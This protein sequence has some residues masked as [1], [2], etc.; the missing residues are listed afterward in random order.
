[1]PVGVGDLYESVVQYRD[2][3][4]GRVGSGVP[5]PQPPGHALAGVGQ[6]AHQRVEAEAPL[7]VNLMPHVW[8]LLIGW[9]PGAPRRLG[10]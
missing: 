7:A 1:V 6:E 3:V 5:G 10:H 4:R 9:P 2:V 8:L